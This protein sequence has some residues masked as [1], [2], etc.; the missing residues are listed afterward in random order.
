MHFPTRYFVLLPLT[1]ALSLLTAS[2]SE[3]KISQCNKIIE[4]ANKAV[5]ETKS[6]T[7][8]TQQINPKATLKAADAMEKASK[9][10]ESI[11][12]SDQKLQDYQSRFIKMYREMSK[13]TRDFV[14]AYEKKNRPAAE[15]AVAELKKATAPEKQLVDDINIYCTG[16]KLP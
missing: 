4:V 15:G 2:C 10:M 3:S 6:I 16:K 11:R 7:N 9:E 13:A 12:V 14:A 1:V 5:N 8:G